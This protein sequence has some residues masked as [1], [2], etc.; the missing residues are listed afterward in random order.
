MILVIVFFLAVVAFSHGRVPIASQSA[1]ATRLSA[2]NRYIWA[3][4]VTTI[5]FGFLGSALW[6][7]VSQK[8]FK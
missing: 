3:V 7:F 1:F 5:F 2:V 6:D 4:A 8:V